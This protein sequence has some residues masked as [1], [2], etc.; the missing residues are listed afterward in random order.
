MQQIELV[1]APAIAVPA[2]DSGA[3]MRQAAVTLAGACAFLDVYAP[4]PILPLLAHEFHAAP[5]RAGLTISATTFGVALAAPFVGMLADRW[6]RK[7]LIVGSLLAMAVPTLLAASA[8]TLEMLVFWRFLQGLCIPGIISAVLA[9]INEEWTT[10]AASATASYVTGTVF[11]GFVGRMLTGIFAEHIGW[12][13]AF[14]AL[15]LLTLCGGAAI[16]HWLPASRRF[17]A[18]TGWRQAVDDFG[19]HL[20]N[21]VLLATYAVGFN[22]L[23]SL[24]A[25]FTYITFHLAQAPYSL[26]PTAQGLL[27][28]VYLLGLFVTPASGRWIERLG[29]RLA[30]T[31][32]VCAAASGVLLTLTHALWVVILG[33]AI[34]SSGVFVC[35]AAASTH[36]AFAARRAKSAASGLYVCFYYV[37]GSVGA[38]LPGLVY[39]HAGWPGCVALIVAFQ[40]IAA[41]VAYRFWK[42]VSEPITL[43][44]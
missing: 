21:P 2:R 14:V 25:T 29:Q 9:Y 13:L 35:Q 5:A 10:G 36:V 20:R 31:L 43:A 7:P 24:V 17:V 22:V 3:V 34:S 42:P 1:R 33:L 30:V 6:G 19:E 4:Q 26:G 37:G 23:F 32:A 38:V 12:R 41:A 39:L 27:F 40:A 18:Q 44:A 16:A 15:G 8:P 11:G 28:C